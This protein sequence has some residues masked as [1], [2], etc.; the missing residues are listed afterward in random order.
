MKYKVMLA[1]MIGLVTIDYIE[2]MNYYPAG[3]GRLRKSTSVHHGLHQLR[4]FEETGKNISNQLTTIDQHKHID[5]SSVMIVRKA[6]GEMKEDLATLLDQHGKL[7]KQVQRLESRGQGF[8]KVL[9][10]QRELDQKIADASINRYG[11]STKSQRETL[12]Q[13]CDDLEENCQGLLGMLS[14]TQQDVKNLQ[15]ITTSIMKEATTM[16]KEV[17]AVLNA[18][19]KEKIENIERTLTTLQNKPCLTY[20]EIQQVK[21][22]FAEST[23]IVRTL[24]KSEHDSNCIEERIRSTERNNYILIGLNLGIFLTAFWHKLDEY[25]HVT[26][27][28]IKRSLAQAFFYDQLEDFELEDPWE[29]DI[30]DDV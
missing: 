18:S 5:Q 17:S 13:R 28:S 12:A 16:L 6:I 7:S 23:Y 21:H 2:A 19:Q 25:A 24:K 8:Q 20:E 15:E 30:I 1:M 4:N 29:P 3:D 14:I 27:Y 11:V 22:L 10:L 9:Q 26:Y